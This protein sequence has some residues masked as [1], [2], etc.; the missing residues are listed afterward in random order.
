MQKK[1]LWVL[2]LMSCCVLGIT[3]LQLYWNYQNYQTTVANFKKDSNDAL[4]KAVDGEIAL[5]HQKIKSVAKKWLAD[6]SF[7]TI[8]C[9]IKNRDSNTVFNISDTHPYAKSDRPVS[10]GIADFKEKLRMS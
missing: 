7:I 8:T 9:D 6:T 1:I 4:A 10:I 3:G 5:R 2:I